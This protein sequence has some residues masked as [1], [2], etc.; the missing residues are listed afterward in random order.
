LRSNKDIEAL[1]Q[2]VEDLTNHVGHLENEIKD[3][4]HENEI[5]K[6]L[7]HENEMLKE[8]LAKYENPKNSNNSSIPPSKDENRPFKSKSLCKKTGPKPGGQRRAMKERRWKWYQ[9]LMRS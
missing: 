3:L 7:K 5:L 6:D 2:K 4:K 8:R 9:I 1:F